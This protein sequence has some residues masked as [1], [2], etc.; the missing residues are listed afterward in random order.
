[1][2]D[3]KNSTVHR[4]EPTWKGGVLTWPVAKSPVGV[5]VNGDRNVL[6]TSGTE[7][8]LQIFSPHGDL[9]SQVVYAGGEIAIVCV[10]INN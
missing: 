9:L 6:V 5:S 3:Y 7:R 10:E 8:K 2:T 4:V 1:M